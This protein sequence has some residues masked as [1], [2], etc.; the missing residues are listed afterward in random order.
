MTLIL[1]AEFRRGMGDDARRAHDVIFGALHN[2]AS[3]TLFH[4]HDEEGCQF[5]VVT[6]DHEINAAGWGARVKRVSTHAFAPVA[7]AGEQ[8]TFTVR[9]SPVRRNHGK[10]SSVLHGEDLDGFLDRLSLRAG[11]SVLEYVMEE[12]EPCRISRR[13]E[14]QPSGL[15]QGLLQVQDPALFVDALKIGIGRTR[16]F[17]FGLL[18]TERAS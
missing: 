7:E 13:Q 10:I 3:R 8:R 15:F 2:P 1:R 11:F 16:T 4:R 17:G 12:E 14:P 9:L 6:D 5:T 18:M